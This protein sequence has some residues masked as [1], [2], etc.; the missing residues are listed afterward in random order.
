MADLS[1]R[2]LNPGLKRDKLAYWPLYYGRIKQ[3][4]SCCSGSLRWGVRCVSCYIWASIHTSSTFCPAHT[5]SQGSCMSQVEVRFG[6]ALEAWRGEKK[7]SK[8][9]GKKE[10]SSS[11]YISRVGIEV[12]KRES[13]ACV[14][15][16]KLEGEEG[17]GEATY[18]DR[19]LSYPACSIRCILYGEGACC[20]FGG[21]MYEWL[22]ASF[23]YVR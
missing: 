7:R 8:G 12:Q 4:G 23:W 11:R 14:Q 2:E 15:R 18:M 9:K 16:G 21:C 22:H 17:L 19:V 1:R 10:K 5:R 20:R 3:L 13:R 6:L